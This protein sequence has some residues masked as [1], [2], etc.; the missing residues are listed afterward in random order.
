M[1]S[2]QNHFADCYQATAPPLATTFVDLPDAGKEA[3]HASSNLNF[4]A[5]MAAMPNAL[6][7]V[8]Y[9][10]SWFNY[11]PA[12]YEPPFE[13]DLIAQLNRI[14]RY[15][16]YRVAR[17][18]DSLENMAYGTDVQE[19]EQ[20]QSPEI[21]SA[22]AAVELYQPRF[23]LV[24]AGGNDMAG[25]NGIYLENYLN[26]A[27]TGLPPLRRERALDTFA[28]IN[29]AALAY[30]I[31]KIKATKAD[32]HIFIHGYDYAVPDG[33]AVLTAP[34]GFDF[35]GPWLLAAFA[36]KRTWPQSVRQGVIN[37]LIDMHNQT[38]ADLAARDPQVHHIDCRGVLRNDPQT[39]REDWANELHPTPSGFGKIAAR[40]DQVISG[41]FQAAVR[42]RSAKASGDML[43][44][45]RSSKGKTRGRKDR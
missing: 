23:F 33:R 8:A 17:P 19:D 10:D 22:E 9:G 37:D 34:F 38:I 14:G 29:K 11:A 25:Q 42:M 20:P 28:N 2:T 15:N 5:R 4:G 13:G 16:I 43:K 30:I 41:V 7:G 3:Y 18:G 31:D 45:G 27:T 6:I 44:S 39:Y 24:S 36:R 1:Y 12:L 40:F 21:L 32:I 35:I 26:H